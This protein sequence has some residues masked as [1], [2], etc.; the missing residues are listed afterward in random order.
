M[1]KQ[2]IFF[3]AIVLISCN[4][5][6]NGEKAK[7]LTFSYTVDTVQIHAENHLFFLGYGLSQPRLSTDD[8]YLYFFDRIAHAIEKVDLIDEEYVS[9]MYLDKEGP[10]GIAWPQDYVPKADQSF[11]FVTQ[12]NFVELDT[13]GEL[14]EFSDKPESVFT[15]PD[16]KNFFRGSRVS[17]DL[18]YL[19]GITNNFKE[20]QMLG[21]IGM[22]DSV[23]REMPIDSMGYRDKLVVNLG[24]TKMRS[25]I[26]AVYLNGKI[27]VFHGDGIDLYTLDPKSEKAIF[28]DFDIKLVEKRKPGNFPKNVELGTEE[29]KNAIELSRKE[30][31]FRSIV[32]DSTNHLYYRVASKW[33]ES[34]SIKDIPHQ[35]LFIFDENLNLLH[36][37]DLSGFPAK[38]FE[39]FASNGKLW[40]HNRETEELEFFVFDFELK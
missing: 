12:R 9:T 28:H 6:K 39:Y 8:R 18:Q 36:E 25:Q 26:D 23:Y 33:T 22:D 27:T 37:E 31:S 15:V 5:E 32:Y 38:I 14:I 35:Y 17:P 3:L 30:V 2:L 24:R 16:D 19:F 1:T 4:S 13:N 21:W 10:K 7:D 20:S 40:V 29:S 34:Q 11:Y